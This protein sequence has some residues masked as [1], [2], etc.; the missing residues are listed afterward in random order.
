M[1][2]PGPGRKPMDPSGAKVPIKIGLAPRHLAILDRLVQ[3]KKLPR[4][5]IVGRLLER[6]VKRVDD[7][8]DEVAKRRG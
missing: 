3:D 2:G 8:V 7:V 1:K 4:G 6:T 5:E